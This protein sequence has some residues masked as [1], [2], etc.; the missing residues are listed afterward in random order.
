MLKSLCVARAT[1]GKSTEEWFLPFLL[2]SHEE[3][4][5]KHPLYRRGERHGAVEKRGKPRMCPRDK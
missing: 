2:R 1:P 5:G 3:D 4:R